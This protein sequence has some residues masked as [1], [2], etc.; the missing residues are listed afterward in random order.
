[1]TLIGVQTLLKGLLQIILNPGPAYILKETD[2]CF[3]VN[4]NE[5]KNAAFLTTMVPSERTEWTHHR[6]S[7]GQSPVERYAN[8]T[9]GAK[10][11]SRF[12]L[13]GIQRTTNRFLNRG[14]N[15][16]NRSISESDT[17][18]RQMNGNS[19]FVISDELNNNL[20]K[21]N[22]NGITNPGK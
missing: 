14:N 8:R 22:Y 18:N 7:S 11:A 21:N 12:S 1:M 9:T 5:E 17:H 20:F 15:L 16:F 19:V 2:I 4:V 13:S 10:R 3:Y 6:A